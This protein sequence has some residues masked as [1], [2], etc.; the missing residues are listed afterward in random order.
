MH[1]IPVILTRPEGANTAFAEIIAPDVRTRLHC[2]HSPLLDIVPIRADVDLTSAD[3]AIFTST[4]GVRFAPQGDK[5]QAFCVGQKTTQAAQASGWEAVFSGATVAELKEFVLANRPL[6]Q[7]HHYSGIHT[8]GN[9]AETLSRVGLNTLHVPI[10]DQR[11]LPLSAEAI[12]VLDGK[13]PV[14]VPLFSPRTATHF[15]ETAPATSA[16]HVVA[17]SKAVADSL[18]KIRPASLVIASGPTALSMATCVENLVR[19][20]SLG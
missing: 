3:C 12:E 18:D 10:Y 2:I 4:N 5:R 19:A 17:M 16:V 8:R 9:V 15:A 6:G 7:I 14:L 11:L 13:S 20:D 1:H